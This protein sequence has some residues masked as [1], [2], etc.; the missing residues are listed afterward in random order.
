MVD[1]DVVPIVKAVLEE[2]DNPDVL[3]QGAPAVVHGEGH[4]VLLFVGVWAMG[5]VAGD[6]V[7]LRDLCL[8]NDLLEVILR[9]MQSSSK[10][11]CQRNAVWAVSNLCRGRPKP[12]L[13]QLRPAI[14]VLAGMV[15]LS[16][17]T[18]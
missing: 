13:Q 7:P 5:N 18:A 4:M 14:P 15:K 3:E 11:S 6:C 9:I 16:D 8:Q 10:L 1:L 12:Q 2:S 17:L